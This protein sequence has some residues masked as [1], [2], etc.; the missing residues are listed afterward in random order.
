MAAE[1]FKKRQK[2]M[3]RREK[4]QKKLARRAER[5]LEKPKSHIDSEARNP[6][7]AQSAAKHGPTIL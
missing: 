4:Q 1:T 5:K 2:E 3:A 6:D 7:L